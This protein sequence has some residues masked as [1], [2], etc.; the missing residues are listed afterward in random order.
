MPPRGPERIE[1]EQGALL[2]RQML[3]RPGRAGAGA[4]CFCCGSG[5]LLGGRFFAS[6][7][8]RHWAF[9][10]RVG[11]FQANGRIRTLGS[12]AIG[13]A[14]GRLSEE[15]GTVESSVPKS[16][17]CFVLMPFGRKTDAT[18]R[19]TD[20]D[21]VYREIIAPAVQAAG[22]EPIRADEERV[23][24]TIHKPMFERLMLCDYA[25]ADITGANPNVYY[26]LGIRH[27]M[28]PRSTV[29]LF[30]EGTT[31]PFDIALLARHP[32]PHRRER[33]AAR[34]EIV[35]R[36]GG[37]ASS[38][39]RAQIRTTTARC[40]SCS[41]T[42]RGS[43]SITARPTSSAT[44][45][46]IPGNTR[47]AWRPPARRAQPAVKAVVA[48]PALANLHEVEAGIVVD[49]FLSL[50]DVEVLRRHDRALRPHAAAAAAGPHHARAVRLRAQPR[51]AGS[52]RPRR[53]SRRCCRSSGRRARPT[54]CS[55]A[56]TRTAGRSRA[57]DK[58]AGCAA[59]CSGAR[60]TPISRA[61]RPTGATPI[62]GINAV[63][64]MEMQ[65]KP[66]PRQAEILPV[67][68]YAATA[69]GAGAASTTG[70]TRRCW[71]SP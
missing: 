36:Q 15:R 60:S 34:A 46:T 20:F 51:S 54:G 63:T 31:L 49:L 6:L 42:C 4:A 45:S 58:P 56:S 12:V 25:V 61:S 44:A 11:L 17:L 38:R 57:R 66:D 19:I 32:L 71:S 3:L 41:T 7:F 33:R 62:P 10:L 55:A 24:G 35:R 1:F 28:R 16:P 64:L 40:S 47:S 22:L 69:E 21:A 29:I 18:G 65:D 70:T 43:R 27:A 50:R 48:E 13:A 30:A 9:S 39:R 2:G 8:G 59:R 67:V 23:G 37:R 52:R 68:R 14:G 5:G 53:C 26:E